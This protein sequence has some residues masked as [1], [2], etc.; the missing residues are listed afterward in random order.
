MFQRIRYRLLLS[1]LVVFASLLGIFAIAVRFAFTRSLSEQITDKLTA[2]GKGAAANVES[3]KGRLT[4]ESDFRPQDL[5]A[6]HQGLEWFDTQGNLINQQ[7]KTVLNLPFL[8]NKMVQT[9][10]GKVPIR[11]V[12]VP[13][14]ASDNGELVGYVRVSQSLEE[15]DET[16]Q[17]LDLVLSSGIIITL[18]FSGIGGILLTRQ[19]M[20]PIEQSFQKLKQFTADASH[21]LRSPLMAI[22]INAEL[23]L[24]YPEE[25][26]P[27][28]AEKFQAI[29]SATNQMTRLTEDLLLLARTDKV[30]TQNR[31]TL[32]LTSILENLIQLYKPQAEA[33]QINFKFK[34]I[35]NLQLVGDSVQLTRLF[36]NLIENALYYT[37]S[38]GIVEIRTSRVGSQ[39]Y[40]NVQDTGVGIAPEHIDKVFERFWRADQ[41]RS[42]WSGGS[43]LGLAIA[44]AIAQN[45]GGLISVTSQLGVGSCFTVHLPTS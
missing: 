35:T 23:P 3:E 15:F 8:P 12:T 28:D 45:H 36:T 41:S 7:G 5:I 21:E 25:I 16:L 4:V 14:F 37:P 18:V 31:D 10:T 38:G 34:L 27:K 39:L 29:A 2:I 20:Q 17:K 19:A 43:G 33:K 13:I 11:V 9:Q 1:Y 32:N 40:V 24:Q 6:S 30:P 44:Q 22:K 42:Y 26:G